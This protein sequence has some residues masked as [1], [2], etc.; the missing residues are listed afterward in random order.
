MGLLLLPQAGV[1]YYVL[2]PENTES[3]SVE[4]GAH[5]GTSGAADGKPGMNVLVTEF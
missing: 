3:S 5:R 2:G 1:T 4:R